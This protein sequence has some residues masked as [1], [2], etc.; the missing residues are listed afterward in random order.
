MNRTSP[1]ATV[2]DE[3]ATWAG[4]AAFTRPPGRFV[5]RPAIAR[6]CEPSQSDPRPPRHLLAGCLLRLAP[7]D[8]SRTARPSLVRKRESSINGSTPTARSIKS[9]SI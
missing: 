8:P 5:G 6:R 1:A 4:P 3:V 7:P 9:K 2:L